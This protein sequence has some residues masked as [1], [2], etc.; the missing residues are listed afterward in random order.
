M[1]SVPEKNIEELDLHEGQSVA[2]FGAGSGAYTL[3]AAAVLKGAGRVYAVDVQKDLLGRLEK[4]CQE[5]HFG[6]VS[7]VW[8]NIEALGGTKLREQSVDV[9]IVSNVLF[10]TPDKKTVI[11]E[12]KRVLKYGGRLLLIDWSG[13]FN[14]MGPTSEQVFSELAARKLVESLDFTFDRSL[15]AGNY[16]YGLIFRKGLYQIPPK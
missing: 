14:N 15:N 11:E 6:N 12:A 16:H 1:F 13:S 7:F 10:Q 9:V 4:I 5:K 8:G 2:D 3:A